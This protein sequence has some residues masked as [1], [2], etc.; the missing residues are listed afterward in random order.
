[1]MAEWETE[2]SRVS[3]AMASDPKGAR[4]TEAAEHRGPAVSR[5]EV[6][7]STGGSE[8]GWSCR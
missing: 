4:R 3:E 1:M 7:A 2:G 5:A 8:E 6:A